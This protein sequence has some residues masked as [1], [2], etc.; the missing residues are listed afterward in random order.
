MN[1]YPK[2]DELHQGEQISI[3]RE[4][5]LQHLL[6][7]KD[8]RIFSSLFNHRLIGLS[9]YHNGQCGFKKSFLA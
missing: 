2:N 7:D 3:F 9:G 1:E 6:I 8:K 4:L 5:K